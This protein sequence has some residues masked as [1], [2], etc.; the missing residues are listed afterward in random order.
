MQHH[1]RSSSA[2]A[3]PA[4]PHRASLV[5]GTLAGLSALALMVMWLPATAASLSFAKPTSVD[6]G[7]ATPPTR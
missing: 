2:G 7:G 4:R 5:A 6:G 1:L 3:L